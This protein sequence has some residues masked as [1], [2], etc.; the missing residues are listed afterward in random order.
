[1]PDNLDVVGFPGVQLEAPTVAGGS[2]APVHPL[3]LERAPLP[4][5]TEGCVLAWVGHDVSACDTGSDLFVEAESVFTNIV[6]KEAGSGCLKVACWLVAERPSR[7]LDYFGLRT[8]YRNLEVTLFVGPTRAEQRLTVAILRLPRQCGE[9]KYWDIGG[10]CSI[11]QLT[12]RQQTPSKWVW[13]SKKQWISFF[14]EVGLY[15]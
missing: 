2:W 10:I 5:P 7:I 15:D 3:T 6:V 9:M 11:L 13:N 8:D 12:S 4:Q 1:M 14:K